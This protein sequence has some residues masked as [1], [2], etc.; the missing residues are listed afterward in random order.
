M[1]THLSIHPLGPCGGSGKPWCV[2]VIRNTFLTAWSSAASFSFYMTCFLPPPS[3]PPWGHVES[4]CQW[5]L[6]IPQ[7]KRVEGRKKEKKQTNARTRPTERKEDKAK[8]QSLEESFPPPHLHLPP[9]LPPL[10]LTPPRKSLA[11]RSMRSRKDCGSF[12]CPSL[13]S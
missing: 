13:S 12:P 6:P 9:L 10:P 4:C 3:S 8:A 7:T 1:Y 11:C 2:C 5:T